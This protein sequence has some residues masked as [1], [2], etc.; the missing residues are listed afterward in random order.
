MYQQFKRPGGEVSIHTDDIAR[1][2]LYYRF[3]GASM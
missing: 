3:G 2:R 1:F